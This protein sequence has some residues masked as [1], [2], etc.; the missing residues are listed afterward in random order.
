MV[1]V[2][3]APVSSDLRSHES[4][5]GR[6]DVCRSGFLKAPSGCLKPGGQ[7]PQVG[8]AHNGS[9]HV[10]QSRQG[11]PGVRVGGG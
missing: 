5:Q 7:W 3:F 11:S 8:D 9:L 2:G 10:D 1:L 6:C 4:F